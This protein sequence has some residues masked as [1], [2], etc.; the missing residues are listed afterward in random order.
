MLWSIE[1]AIKGM[2]Y[3]PINMFALI[4]IQNVKD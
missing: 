1:K 3:W 4:G 2:Y